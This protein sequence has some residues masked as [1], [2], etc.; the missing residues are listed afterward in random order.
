MVAVSNNGCTS[1][2]RLG[3]SLMTLFFVL[4]SAVGTA[5]YGNE[6]TV[7]TKKPAQV[8]QQ[9]KASAQS[10]ININTATLAELQ[11]LPRIG[12]KTAQ[13]IIEFRSENGA[14]AS[15]EEIMNVKG[16]GEKTFERLKPLIRI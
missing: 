13:R 12:V 16:I 11:K 15:V 10:A 5:A 3:R 9:Q 2:V 6:P 4:I 8:S 1:R 7:K 14:F